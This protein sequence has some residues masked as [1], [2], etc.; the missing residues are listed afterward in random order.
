MHYILTKSQYKQATEKLN[1]EGLLFPKCINPISPKIIKG[2]LSTSPRN[3]PSFDEILKIIS[4]KGEEIVQFW[5]AL[6]FFHYL[7]ETTLI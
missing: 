3:R 6:I 5:K 2:C 7:N 1:Y 4:G